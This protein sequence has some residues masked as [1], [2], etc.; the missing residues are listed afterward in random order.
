MEAIKKKKRKTL[1]FY[2]MS[3]HKSIKKRI[4]RYSPKFEK[5]RNFFF[6]KL[7]GKL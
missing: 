1:I 4:I 3:R 5:N 2:Y 6:F 7:F